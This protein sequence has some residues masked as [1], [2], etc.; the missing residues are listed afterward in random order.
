V[1]ADKDY[2]VIFV[3]GDTGKYLKLAEGHL[4]ANILDLAR[5]GLRTNVGETK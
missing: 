1:V 5:Q 4:T 3:R 2:N